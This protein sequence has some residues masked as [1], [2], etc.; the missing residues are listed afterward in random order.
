[1][2][3]QKQR[4]YYGNFVVFLFAIYSLIAIFTEPVSK[5]VI[6]GVGMV[7]VLGLLALQKKMDMNIDEILFVLSLC[8]IN[9]S[10]VSV[11]G[12][13]YS[14]F[15]VTWFMLSILVLLLRIIY[16]GIKKS[17]AFGVFILWLVFFTIS[18]SGREFFDYWDA[19]KQFINLALFL[20]SILIGE[21]LNFTTDKAE[22]FRKVYLDNTVVFAGIVCLQ[23]F[24]YASTGVFYGSGDAYVG[25]VTFA[26]SFGDYSFASLYIA[27][28][29]VLLVVQFIEKKLVLNKLSVLLKLLILFVGMMLTNARTGVAA[30]IIAIFL[31]IFKKILYGNKRAAVLVLLAVPV[32]LWIIKEQVENRGGQSFL[33]SSGRGENYITGLKTFLESPILGSGF[34]IHNY[35]HSLTEGLEA[36]P[37]NMFIQFLAQ[38]GVIGTILLIVLLFEPFKVALKGRNPEAW[39]LLTMFLGAMLIPDIASSHYASALVIMGMVSY[40]ATG[41]LRGEG[42]L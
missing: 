12:G 24:L 5:W 1:M 7:C 19:T 37:H 35:T 20:I 21:N 8:S 13:D 41:Y 16:F 18:L 10:F 31:C 26:A 22:F 17:V 11:L 30:M 28:G 27:T 25:R 42:K 29:I 9:T 39:A 38:F 40:K 6:A 36:I 15:P 2:E 4:L 14:A 32:A 33:D 23:G 3:I 34:G